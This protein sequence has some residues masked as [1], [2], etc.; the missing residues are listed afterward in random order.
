MIGG[1]DNAAIVENLVPRL[2]TDEHLDAVGVDAL[3]EQ[4]EHE[5]LFRERVE[6]VAQGLDIRQ[7]G[8]IHQLRLAGDEEFL[9]RRDA[10]HCRLRHGNNVEHRP[11]HRIACGFKVCDQACPDLRQVVADVIFVDVVRG[12]LQ[13][14][15]GVR[16]R[17]SQHPVLHLAVIDH[18]NREHAA[19]GQ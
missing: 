10:F 2:A 18:Q 15:V 17:R 4:L 16:L 13:F 14:I 12:S 6:Q 19:F 8:E 11:V 5:L 7:L 9:A 1:R 3:V